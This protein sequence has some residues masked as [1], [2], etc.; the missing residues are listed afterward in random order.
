M[1]QEV[2]VLSLSAIL[3]F[4]FWFFLVK[5]NL[6]T[7]SPTNPYASLSLETKLRNLSHMDVSNF[8]EQ[9]NFPLGQEHVRL[10]ERKTWQRRYCQ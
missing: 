2:A 9:K 4:K 7:P 1:L 10:H 6:W 5:A 8:F 3:H